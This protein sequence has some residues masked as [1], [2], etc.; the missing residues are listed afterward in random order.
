MPV[1]EGSIPPK[2]PPVT[3][4]VVGVKLVGVMEVEEEVGVGVVVVEE[5]GV[6]V[7]LPASLSSV[8]E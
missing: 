1:P 8:K 3:P 5:V 2:T 7:V 4:P 6:V